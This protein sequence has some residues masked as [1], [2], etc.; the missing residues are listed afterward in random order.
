M[1]VV[2]P[3]STLPSMPLRMPTMLLKTLREEP[4]DAGCRAIASSSSIRDEVRSKRRRFA[5]RG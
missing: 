5:A 4:A 3:L 1:A 2:D